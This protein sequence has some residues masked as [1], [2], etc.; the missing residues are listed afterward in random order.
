MGFSL[1][2]SPEVKKISNHTYSLELSLWNINIS[3][4]ILVQFYCTSRQA[5]HNYVYFLKTRHKSHLIE[6]Q[7]QGVTKRCRLSWRTNSAFV[8]ERK[9]GGREGVA[10]S[11]SQWV[12]AVVH[13]SP[14]KLWRSNSIF[15][16]WSNDKSI[17]K[18]KWF[19]RPKRK[20]FLMNFQGVVSRDFFTLLW[21]T[22]NHYLRNC[23]IVWPYALADRVCLCLVIYWIQKVRGGYL[24][25]SHKEDLAI[26]EEGFNYFVPVL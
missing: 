3:L 10:G 21:K 2:Y 9:C 22:D 15:N 17:F 14:N 7:M 18:N 24:S 4:S 5:E 20:V 23:F 1:Q 25:Y 13:R 11:Y 12:H 26:R 8:Y 6:S 16:L 19:L